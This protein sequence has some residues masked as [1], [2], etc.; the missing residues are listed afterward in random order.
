MNS[1]H[2]I[3]R[4]PMP[5]CLSNAPAEHFS[6]T[7]SRRLPGLLRLLLSVWQPDL[8]LLFLE[9]S[10]LRTVTQYANLWWASTVQVYI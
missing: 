1:E 9:T 7:G 5:A 6:R 3:T 2:V 8:L 4:Y 10:P